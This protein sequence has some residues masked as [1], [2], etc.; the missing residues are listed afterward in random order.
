MLLSFSW[1]I[2]HFLCVEF[3]RVTEEK[4]KNLFIALKP[5]EILNCNW[6]FLI[7]PLFDAWRAINMRTRQNYI[8]P[9]IKANTAFC[10]VCI[11]PA[12]RCITWAVGFIVDRTKSCQIIE[13]IFQAFFLW[14]RKVD[15][16]A[17]VQQSHL[18]NNMHVRCMILNKYRPRDQFLVSLTLFDKITPI[19]SLAT[20]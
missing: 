15:K 14:I 16:K 17:F 18:Q 12:Q 3:L 10:C 2:G 19:L 13:K 1:H 6:I 8:R 9:T 11:S 7:L 5:F 20:K 4:T